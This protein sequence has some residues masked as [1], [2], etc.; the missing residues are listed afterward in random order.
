MNLKTIIP[1]IAILSFASCSDAQKTTDVAVDQLTGTKI[2]RASL[3]EF[4]SRMQDENVQLLDVR[5]DDEYKAGHIA[6]AQQIDYFSS[7]FK[8]QVDKL[9][10]EKAVLIYCASGNR[11]SKAIEVMKTMGFKE[12]VELQGGYNA[13]DE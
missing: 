4:K 3:G 6:D 12:I 7:D 10:R 13:W 1:F 9:D 5:T 2:V 11:S 8:D